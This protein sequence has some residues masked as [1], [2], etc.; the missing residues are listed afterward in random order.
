MGKPK[1]STKLSSLWTSCRM[2][3]GAGPSCSHGSRLSRDWHR[4]GVQ[5]VLLSGV[6]EAEVHRAFFGHV[7]AGAEGRRKVGKSE[8][9]TV[10]E[11]PQLQARC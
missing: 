3:A 8:P 6:V 9:L 2:R 11:T 10:L 4:V 7:S 1:Y 5:E